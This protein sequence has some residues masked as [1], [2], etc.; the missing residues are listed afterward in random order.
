MTQTI[1]PF[2]TEQM[3]QLTEVGGK[4]LNLIRSTQAGLPVPEGFALSVAFAPIRASGGGAKRD[5]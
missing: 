4:A 1:Y 5:S 3:P 2:S